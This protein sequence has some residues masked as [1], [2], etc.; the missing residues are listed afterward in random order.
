[1]KNARRCSLSM[2]KDSPQAQEPTTCPPSLKM[3]HRREFLH[4]SNEF[5]ERLIRLSETPFLFPSIPQNIYLNSIFFLPC[6]GWNPGL[7]AY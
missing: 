1:V 3:G 7:C 4:K 6:W 5:I 2:A